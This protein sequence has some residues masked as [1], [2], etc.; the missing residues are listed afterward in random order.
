MLQ[1]QSL[2]AHIENKVVFFFFRVDR[3]NLP[4]NH[5]S[6]NH[7]NFHTLN[8]AHVIKLVILH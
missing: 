1:N 2:D 6:V 8:Y 4:Q 3:L 7:H 5:C